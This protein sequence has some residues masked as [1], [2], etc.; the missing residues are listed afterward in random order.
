MITHNDNNASE[1][2]FAQRV[3][4]F[5]KAQLIVDGHGGVY[6]AIMRNLSRTGAL[7][8]LPGTVFIPKTFTMRLTEDDLSR[9]CEIIW[10][11]DGLI[12]VAFAR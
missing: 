9:E 10:R 6:D 4:A 5:K 2:R 1:R 12:G 3:R 11:R 8:D 7:I